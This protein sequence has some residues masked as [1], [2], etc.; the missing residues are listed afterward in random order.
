MERHFEYP[1][2]VEKDS[3]GFY[4]VT[5]PDFPEAAT[6]A[7]SVDTAIA[8]GIDCLEEAVAGRMKRGEDIPA[9]SRPEEGMVLIALSALYAMKAALYLALRT[10][11]L[12]QR[13]L[14]AKLGKEENEVR[15]LL[16][17]K[18]AT[19]ISALERALRAVGKRAQVVVGD[20]K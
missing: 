8:E 7:R 10:G 14:A 13:A 6:D 12:S 20:F 5:F 15:R 17:P 18:H 4:L 16:D 2:R 9:P 19:P 11:E 1:A 3:A